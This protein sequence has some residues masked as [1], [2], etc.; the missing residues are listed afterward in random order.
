MG[1][2]PISIV[3]LTNLK[4]L[5]LRSCCY[6]RE[7]PSRMREMRSL[8]HL[9]VDKW[10]ECIPCGIGDLCHLRSMPFFVPGGKTRCSI[11]ELGALDLKDK[12]HIKCLENVK[13]SKEAK[14]AKLILKND[15][16]ELCLSWN[17]KS[18][19]N[20]KENSIDIEEE[21]KSITEP[22]E[23]SKKQEYSVDM[24][25][26]EQILENLQ[27]PDMLSHLVI[28]EFPGKILPKWLRDSQLPNLVHIALVKCIKCEILP[29]FKNF[30]CLKV[31]ILGMLTEVRSLNCLGQVPSLEVLYLL[32]LPLVKC[33]GAEFYGGDVAFIRLE[34]LELKFMPELEEWY[35]VAAGFEFFPHLATLIISMCPK[36]KKIPS[37]FSTIKSLKVTVDDE[38]LLS[39]ITR[40]S[41][42]R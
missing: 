6:L 41:N 32:Y 36:L 14:E 5:R 26:V 15:L 42:V 22:I 16:R 28:K 10:L 2:L 9:D 35:E 12:L 29:E 38:I 1:S 11:R 13:T 25:L 40:V 24:P 39:S 17:L 3:K 19:I 34:Y 33:L 30:E 4:S 37:N 21:G 7:L 20:R 23:L 18:Y 27:P 8:V 31:L